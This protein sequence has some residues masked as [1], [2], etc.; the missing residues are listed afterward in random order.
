MQKLAAEFL[1]IVTTHL[2]MARELMDE[3]AG[4]AIRVGAP[5]N[6]HTLR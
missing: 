6:S 5:E 3:L 4:V 1:P 2:R